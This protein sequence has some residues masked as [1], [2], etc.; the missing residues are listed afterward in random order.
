[1]K[2][3]QGLQTHLL[4]GQSNH[5]F[6]TKHY[7]T[8]F[9]LL[10]SLAL[11][12]A[13]HLAQHR[14]ELKGEII[15]IDRTTRQAIVR[16]EEIPG[17]MKAMTMP[18]QVKDAAAFDRLQIGQKIKAVLIVTKTDSWLEDVEVTGE[19][20]VEPT[21][22]T[23][24]FKIPVEGQLVPDFVLTN[25]DGRRVHLGEY[26]G[27]VVLI[28][29]IYTRCPL[30]DFCPRMTNNFLAIERSLKQDP[31][32]YGHTHLLTVTFDPEFDT[33]KVL[34]QHALSVTSISAAELFPHWEFLTPRL[35]DLGDIAHFFGLST[36]K[37]DG[38]I[39]HSLSTAV[40]DREGKLYRWYHGNSWTTDELL[41][42]TKSAAGPN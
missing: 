23:G 6:P 14:F 33:P 5:S 2:Q 8:A 3:N 11:L 16:H 24:Q 39:T 4:V 38:Q 13:C 30:P 18:Y 25:Q 10:V 15:A 28:T 31:A 27:Q 41:R 34:R 9:F 26:K 40:I 19:A 37:E 21:P 22:A 7:S 32:L 35:E 17:Y 36:W 42:E 1:M 20:P 29:F 12:G